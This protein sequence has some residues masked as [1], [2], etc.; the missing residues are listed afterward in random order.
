MS[1]RID[2]SSDFETRAVRAGTERSQFNE[3]SEALFLTS[4]F[5]FNNAAQAAARFSG[6][7]SGNVYSRFTNPTVTMFEQRLASLEGAQDCAGHCLGDG[8]DHGQPPCDVAGRRSRICAANVSVRR[9]SCFK[10]FVAVR[11]RSDFRRRHRHRSM[12]CGRHCEHKASLLR[13]ALE[14]AN[15]ASRSDPVWS[16]GRAIGVHFRSLITASAL[17]V[18][19]PFDFGVDVVI[20][21]ATNI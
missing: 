9:F 15:G 12:A 20:Q 10:R 11:Y 1:E 4:S 16:F 5:V 17:R 18:A 7:E 8:G 2:E 3:H 21:S 13:N 6:A 19:T 14:P